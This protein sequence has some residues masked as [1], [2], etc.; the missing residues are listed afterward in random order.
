MVTFRITSKLRFVNK[1]CLRTGSPFLTRS[2]SAGNG[3]SNRNASVGNDDGGE[4]DD[5]GDSGF[6]VLNGDVDGGLNTGS[7]AAGTIDSD[8]F[9]AK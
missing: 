6:G 3:G 5:E 9:V 1:S 7:K 2:Q 8:H 4:V